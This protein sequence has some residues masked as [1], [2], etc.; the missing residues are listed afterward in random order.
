MK[1]IYF[2]ITAVIVAIVALFGTTVATV[3]ASAAEIEEDVVDTLVFTFF[4]SDVF[5]Q[6]S[7]SNIGYVMA[8]P[9]EFRV[10]GNTGQIKT[11]FFNTE[12]P[13]ILDSI[14]SPISQSTLTPISI[15]FVE[16]NVVVRSTINLYTYA[17]Y[18]TQAP[19]R[20]WAGRVT[21]IK[22]ET[23]SNGWIFD[24]YNESDVI[25]SLTLWINATRRI[26]VWNY[27][28]SEITRLPTSLQEE[29][30][31][32]YRKGKQDGEITSEQQLQNKFDEGY[33]KGRDYQASLENNTFRDLLS[34]VIDAPLRY[35]ESLLGFDILGTNML[36]LFQVLLTTT[37]LI[38]V[39]RKFT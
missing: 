1:K 19:D 26:T 33:Q 38:F 20:N 28:Q 39:I 6:N 12:N 9:I 37:I 10:S 35:I 24:F 22:A 30:L 23:T 5:S 31:N 32:G 14:N 16:S 25:M 3:T 7:T 27:T 4:S 36:Q 2:N 15:G 29:Y 13:T 21:K 17:Y 18:T 34:S 11:S 8:Y